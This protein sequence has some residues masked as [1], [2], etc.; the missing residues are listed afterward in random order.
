VSLTA[1]VRLRRGELSLDVALESADGET[2][3]VVGPN[4]TG[5]TSLLLALAGLIALDAGRVVVDGRTWEDAGAGI[6]VPTE[7]RELGVVFAEGLLFP[8]LS[9]RDNVAF[10]LRCRGLGRSEARR[11]ADDELER[12]GALGLAGARPRQ[13]SAG[14]AQRVA[15]ARALAGRPRL[16]LADEPLA[17]VDAAAS[18]PLRAHLREQLAA[19]TGTALVVT[20]DPVEAL[21]LADRLLVLDGGRIVQEGPPL[22]VARR[23][24]T[25]FV[26]GLMGVNLIRGWAV[27]RRLKAGSGTELVAAEA[28]GADGPAYASIR[29]SS[30][31]LYP[32][33]PFGS[34]RNVWA[35]T[36]SALDVLG[37][38]VRVRLEGD[39]TVV[40][41]VTPEAVAELVLEP[42]VS[43]WATV[44]ATDVTLYPQ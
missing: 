39:V 38:R 1:E 24:R 13:L 34:P 25:P 22:E 23:P 14:Q 11:A 10:P 5:K 36:V 15:L 44:K 2:L 9:V 27:G 32:D 21:V 41:E 29:P 16:L 3:A 31:A 30:V 26:A 43:V 42:G 7:Q 4:G 28:V 12:L 18:A 33:R 8:H 40:A 19:H 20:H 6:R 35:G 17:A 37:D